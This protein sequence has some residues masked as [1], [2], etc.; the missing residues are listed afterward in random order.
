MTLKFPDPK[1]SSAQL[2]IRDNLGRTPIFECVRHGCQLMDRLVSS[3]ADFNAIDHT[4]NSL[5]HEAAQFEDNGAGMAQLL[6]DRGARIGLKNNENK[7]A[8]HLAVERSNNSM[9][10]FLLI[11]GASINDKDTLGNSPLHLAQSAEVV[12]ALLEAGANPDLPN[13][14]GVKPVNG[15]IERAQMLFHSPSQIKSKSDTLP[16]YF[17]GLVARGANIAGVELFTPVRGEIK[18]NIQE[19]E[20]VSPR[21][22][23]LE[24]LPRNVALEFRLQRSCESWVSLGPIDDQESMANLKTRTDWSELPAEEGIPTTFSVAIEPGTCNV[25]AASRDHDNKTAELTVLSAGTQKI[26]E[27]TVRSDGLKETEQLLLF[28]T[29]IRV[30]VKSGRDWKESGVL[31]LSH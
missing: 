27:V 29:V 9:V 4:G 8:L 25:S 23:E 26:E 2:D 16:R 22:V 10:K 11:K 1:I 6:I 28:R 24:F 21:N 30:M 3:G 15:K 7:T 20:T 17:S 18:R 31:Y 12:S 5:L 19:E 14:G 13:K